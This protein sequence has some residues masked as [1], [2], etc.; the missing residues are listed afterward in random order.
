MTAIRIVTVN[1]GKGDGPYRARLGLLVEQ[2]QELRPD[3]V[4][5]QE[6]FRADGHG[7]DTTSE[8]AR[9]LQMSMFY[10]PARGK[11]REFE[12]QPTWSD[13]GLALLSRRPWLTARTIVLPCDPRDG[14]RIAQVGVTAVNGSPITVANLHLTHLRDCDELRALQL[15][16]VLAD[17]LLC[18]APG[19]ALVCGDFNTTFDGPVLGPLLAGSGPCDLR[20][21]W[22]LGDGDTIRGTLPGYRAGDRC[23]DYILS[24]VRA[25]AEHP[26]F[27]N[28]ALALTRS[29]ADGTLPSDHYAVTTCLHIQ[30]EPR[31]EL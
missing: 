7:V 9:A 5:L 25:N 1:T 24:L 8:L 31:S 22:L 26:R 16:L 19:P 21:T 6:A 2:L 28:S 29:S 15:N 27:T 20:D 3:I 4:A 11:E 10:S 18:E 14:E 17:S 12:G 30:P 23:V 13:S